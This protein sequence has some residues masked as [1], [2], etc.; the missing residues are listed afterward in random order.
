MPMTK[1]SEPYIPVDEAVHH[2]E[3]HTHGHL[4]HRQLY[5]VTTATNYTVTTATDLKKQAVTKPQA[6]HTGTT[7]SITN[8]MI[9]Q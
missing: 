1:I 7:A 4:R 8:I 9:K 3:R 2:N 6:R 5:T